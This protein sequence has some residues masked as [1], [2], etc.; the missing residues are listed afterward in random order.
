[1]PILTRYYFVVLACVSRSVAFLLSLLLD[2][3]W[4]FRFIWLSTSSFYV[5]GQHGLPSNLWGVVRQHVLP[6]LCLISSRLSRRVNKSSCLSIWNVVRQHVLPCLCMISSRFLAV[7]ISR[8][9]WVFKML[10][11]SVFCRVCVWY[12]HVCLAAS[13]SRVNLSIWTVVRQH[14]FPCLCMISSRFASQCQ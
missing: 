2:S 12:L 7:S 9:V 3:N 4:S 5:Y 11:G 14:V 8:V 10:S 1:M 6:C 13:I